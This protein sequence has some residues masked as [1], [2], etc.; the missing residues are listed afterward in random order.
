M[1]ADSLVTLFEP[2]ALGDVRASPELECR[3]W[4]RPDGQICV[5]HFRPTESVSYRP[6]THSEYNIVICLSGAVSKTQMGT[7][8]VIEPADAMMGN[9][10]VEHASGY[11]TDARG[12]EAVCLTVDRRILA[13][14][15]EDARLPLPSGR[16]SPVFLGKLNSR[17]LYSCAL[18]MTQELEHREL[19]HAIVVEGLA[20]RMLVEALRAW[21]RAGVEQ[22]E[23]DWTPRLPRRDFV[24]A[25]E[26]MR[27]CRKDAFRLQHLCRFLGTSEERFTRLFRA[28]THASPASFYNRMLLERGRDLL[29]DRHLSV[30]EVSYLLGFKTSSHFVVAFRRQFGTT[31]LEYRHVCEQS[32]ASVSDTTQDIAIFKKP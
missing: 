28:A 16:R 5:Q 15:L 32:G 13:G 7:T 27:W 25:Y 3:F 31:P 20:M 10:G 21:P 12:C 17:V 8:H 24:R 29:Q 23:V 6:H 11:L 26:F 19:G 22:C 18:D 30:K 9:F 14:L 2:G 4:S 1:F